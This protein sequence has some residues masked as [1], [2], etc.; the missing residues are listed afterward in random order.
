MAFVSL[1]LLPKYELLFSLF[2]DILQL[3]GDFGMALTVMYNIN[4]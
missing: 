4:K 3:V 2:L 1:L